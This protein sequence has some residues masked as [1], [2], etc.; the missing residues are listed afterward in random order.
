MAAAINKDFKPN[1]LNKLNVKSFKV[2]E[3]TIKVKALQ[4]SY[5]TSTVRAYVLE[6]FL[7]TYECDSLVA[8][9]D[10][11]VS[12]ISKVDPLICFDSLKTLKLNLKEIG[13]K[14][15]KVS[16][17]DFVEGTTCINETFSSSLK[18]H[19]KWS[20]STSFYPGESPFSLTLTKR[21]KGATGFTPENGGKFQITSYPQNVGKQLILPFF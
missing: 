21:I 7:S 3:T 20:Y 11:H 2:G 13:L 17:E 12:H 5:K 9:H 16:R 4:H 6:N 19:M 14:R 18:K 10:R 8:I 1:I 15:I